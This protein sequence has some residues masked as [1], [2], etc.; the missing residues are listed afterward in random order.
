MID[1]YMKKSPKPDGAICCLAC[2]N[3]LCNNQERSCSRSRCKGC[4]WLDQELH[5]CIFSINFPR[6]V[7]LEEFAERI[8]SVDIEQQK[9]L[10]DPTQRFVV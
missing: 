8:K 5:K 1:Y 4:I 6:S 3:R 2:S 10:S 7:S 9:R